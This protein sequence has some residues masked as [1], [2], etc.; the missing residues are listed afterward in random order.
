MSHT[1]HHTPE[2]DN[3]ICQCG[4]RPRPDT[5]EWRWNGR[6]WE[7]AHSYPNGFVRVTRRIEPDWHALAHRPKSQTKGPLVRVTVELLVPR[8]SQFTV[9]SGFA[10]C[11]VPSLMQVRDAAEEALLRATMNY[12]THGDWSKCSKA[13]STPEPEAIENAQVVS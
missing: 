10:V 12:E 9:H 1:T 4:Q 5:A 11:A 8:S 6:H 7:H 13:D 2:R 3:W